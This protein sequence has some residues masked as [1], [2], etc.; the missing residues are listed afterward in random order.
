MV[1]L[2][3][4]LM[5]ALAVS[6]MV[7]LAVSLMMLGATTL[8]TWRLSSIFASSSASGFTGPGWRVSVAS[9]FLASV[10]LL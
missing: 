9:A 4:S 3:V 5:V 6:L 1:A 2:A 10:A 7:A 8:L